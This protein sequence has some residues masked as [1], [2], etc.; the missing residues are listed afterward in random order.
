M[1]AM[2]RVFSTGVLIIICAAA[3]AQ[4]ASESSQ[5]ATLLEYLQASRDAFQAR[6]DARSFRSLEVHGSG[7]NEM[8]V[9]MEV[10]CPS[11]YHMRVFRGGRL[12]T[13]FYRV[14][15][16]EY[17]RVD[18]KW[19]AS[20]APAS[21]SHCPSA[22]DVARMKATSAAAAQREAQ[23]VDDYAA[24]MQVTRGSIRT[25][26]GVRCQEWTVQSLPALTSTS[27][28]PLQPQLQHRPGDDTQTMCLSLQ[29]HFTMEQT[30]FV[31]GTPNPVLD[32]TTYY[33]WNKPITIPAPH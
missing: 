31:A 20:P 26:H 21:G 4:P 33:D 10:S 30:R 9:E 23:H 2:R 14:D 32:V 27:P 7:A 16:K 28:G 8:R 13:D 19:Q 17:R 3:Q 25:V 1:R 12:S 6:M 24:R 18:G 15:G 5:R 11:G 29:D 22:T